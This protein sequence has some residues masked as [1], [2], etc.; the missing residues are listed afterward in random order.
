MNAYHNLAGW[1]RD[2][3]AALQD[4]QGGNINPMSGALVAQLNDLLVDIHEMFDDGELDG[5][6]ETA[7]ESDVLPD[8][9]I[10]D[11]E[12]VDDG[13]DEVVVRRP[14]IG[15]LAREERRAVGS[16][17][18][19]VVDGPA[20]VA[21]PVPPVVQKTGRGRSRKPAPVAGAGKRGVSRGKK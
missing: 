18:S 17:R 9:D 5:D 15:R 11:D 3:R 4:T 1:L 13:H 21:V 12:H 2:V 14:R 20:P 10:E 19:G 16:G 7:D 6:L 8:D